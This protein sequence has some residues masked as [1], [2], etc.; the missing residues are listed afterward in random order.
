VIEPYLFR[1]GFVVKG[2]S[3]LRVLTEKGRNH[4]QGGYVEVNKT[5]A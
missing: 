1:D 4:I 2:K 3:A 5:N